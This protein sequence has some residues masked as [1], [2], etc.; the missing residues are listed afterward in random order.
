MLAQTKTPAI[1]KTEV[2]TNSNQ[3]TITGQNFGAVTPSVMLDGPL[4]LTVVSF[5]DA[6]VV[7]TLPPGIAAG[8]YQLTLTNLST[9][10]TGTFIA[11][12]GAVGPAGPT[13]PAGA[14]GF[15]GAAGPT[16]P[17]GPAGPQGPAGPAGPNGRMVNPLAQTV[18]NSSG[19]FTPVTLS[20]PAFSSGAITLDVAN[21][22]IV[23]GTP[24]IFVVTGEILWANN[25]T[26]Y[27]V[28]SVLRNGGEI[29]AVSSP[30]VNGIDT[31]QTASTIQRFTA[32]DV[33]A[34]SAGQ[35]SGGSLA[36]APFIGRGAALS[37]AW[38]GN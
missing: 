4:P 2:S 17:T 13:G 5:T 25:A 34:M 35:T 37:V 18:P 26:G 3:L 15:P 27:R 19:S 29:A 28:L 38:V 1:D 6:M 12:I 24:G 32:G 31:L 20:F 16:G 22:R 7:A 8:S 21:N 36:T 10:K 9:N 11:T 30:A 14:Q 23:I 33:I